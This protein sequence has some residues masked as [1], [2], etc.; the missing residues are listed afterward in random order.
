MFDESFCFSKCL[1]F[2]E[3]ELDKSRTW[4]PRAGCET[5]CT[6][7]AGPERCVPQSVHCPTCATNFCSNCRT[8]WHAGVPCRPEVS[9]TV[10][11]TQS[12]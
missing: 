6:V 4:C 8:N 10:Q 2:S 5:V 12:E 11:S 3:V 7:C 9:L 1:Y